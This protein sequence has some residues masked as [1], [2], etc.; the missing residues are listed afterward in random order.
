MQRT[1]HL[2]FAATG[3]KLISADYRIAN[4]AVKPRA[5]CCE[6]PLSNLAF[7]K[8]QEIGIEIDLLID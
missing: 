3:R 2:V 1:S 4:L 5:R 7:Y 6:A 8:R